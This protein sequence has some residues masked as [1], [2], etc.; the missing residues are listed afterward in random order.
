MI[1]IHYPGPLN[2][3]HFTTEPELLPSDILL[4]QP[5]NPH[6]PYQYRKWYSFAYLLRRTSDGRPALRGIALNSYVSDIASHLSECKMLQALGKVLGDKT[7]FECDVTASGVMSAV[8]MVMPTVCYLEFLTQFWEV[9]LLLNDLPEAP[10]FV[11]DDAR[12]RSMRE[13]GGITW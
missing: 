11:D 7:S 13:I 3:I 10:K 4:L 1:A 8:T 6:S 9:A 2:V 5:A 12:L